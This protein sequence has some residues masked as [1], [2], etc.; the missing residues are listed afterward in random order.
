MYLNID[1]MPDYAVDY[2]TDMPDNTDNKPD[3]AKGNQDYAMDYTNNKPDYTQEEISN[4]VH[5]G[6][7]NIE[8]NRLCP[9][10]FVMEFI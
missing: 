5:P 1:N 6:L 10:G 7:T 2:S 9:I 3:Y 8:V 4:L